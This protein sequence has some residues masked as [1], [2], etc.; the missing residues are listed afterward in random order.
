MMWLYL[1]ILKKPQGKKCFVANKILQ[2]IEIYSFEVIV[3]P[4]HKTMKLR[5]LKFLKAMG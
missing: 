5:C 2:Q 1:I 4:S 3:L